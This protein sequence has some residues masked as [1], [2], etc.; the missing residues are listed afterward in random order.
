MRTSWRIIVFVAIIYLSVQTS[1]GLCPS[2]LMTYAAE[3]GNVTLCWRIAVNLTEIT[4]FTIVAIKKPVQLD[5][6]RI[7]SA[8]HD[9]SFFRTYPSRHNGLYV[10]KAKVYADIPAG[11]LIFQ[12]TNY[13][14]AMSNLYC[15]LYEMMVINSIL[16][17]VENPLFLRT[18]VPTTTSA[19]VTTAAPT[20]NATE[21]PRPTNGEAEA[22]TDE[23]YL[24]PFIIVSCFLGVL[25]IVLMVTV[26]CYRKCVRNIENNSSKSKGKTHTKQVE[27]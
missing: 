23:R 16:D 5:L 21:T 12:V 10:G 19:T 13:T 6:E 4:K 3:G 2:P 26:L 1:K 24:T 11:N 27:L 18:Y 15:T 8:S 22:R 20:T 9:G 25:F 17:C 14:S 7:S